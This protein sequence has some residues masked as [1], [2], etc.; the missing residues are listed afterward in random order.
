VANVELSYVLL[1]R[2]RFTVGFSRD[3]HFS[4]DIDEPFY[5]QPGFT[6]SVTQ[7]VGGPWDVQARG[8]W[9]RLDYQRAETGSLD[10]TAP[11]RVDK[12][13]TYGGGVGYRVGRDIRVGLNLDY[14]RRES[15]VAGQNY[16]GFRGGLAATYVVK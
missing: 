8:S 10:I 15:V 14:V 11:E 7:Q 5:I 2:T 16:D 12:Y 13:Q 4:Y 3:I 9:Y 6:L 1:G